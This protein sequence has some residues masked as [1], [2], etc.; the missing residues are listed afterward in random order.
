MAL[1][2]KKKKKTKD[3]IYDWDG[4]HETRG[5]MGKFAKKEKK[6][7]QFGERDIMMTCDNTD[8]IIYFSNV[9]DYFH[10]YFYLFIFIK[11]H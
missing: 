2:K 1:K 7:V 8:K 4:V 5:S 3:D 9:L 11:R 10:N 6:G